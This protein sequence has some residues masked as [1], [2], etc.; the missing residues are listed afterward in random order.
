MIMERNY[1]IASYHILESFRRLVP[2][3]NKFSKMEQYV[4][5][6]G[7]ILTNPQSQQNYLASNILLI[8]YNFQELNFLFVI[9]F[10]ALQDFK[11]CL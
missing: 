7:K 1:K 11:K 6:V 9:I 10:E 5:R 4:F 2:F 3:T 8:A